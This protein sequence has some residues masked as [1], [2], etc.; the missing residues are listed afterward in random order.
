M[1]YENKKGRKSN[2]TI[3]IRL[4]CDQMLDKEYK[5]SL[6]NML[7]GRQ[8][9]RLVGNFIREMETTRKK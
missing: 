3:R 1:K 5:L 8:H 2:V 7:K 4:T 6:I 9:A